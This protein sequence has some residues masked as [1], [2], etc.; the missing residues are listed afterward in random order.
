MGLVCT[1]KQETIEHKFE[2]SLIELCFQLS[3]LE[4][5][6]INCKE[7]QDHKHKQQDNKIQEDKC[8]GQ[9]NITH[10]NEN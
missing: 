2:K 5:N 3:S 6:N 4:G 9:T 7:D 8:Q 1:I 10:N